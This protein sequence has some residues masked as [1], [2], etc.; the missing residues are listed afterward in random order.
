VPVARDSPRAAPG[1][2]L[3]PT[4]QRELVTYKTEHT[5]FLPSTGGSGGVTY[6]VYTA[7]APNI[8]LALTALI[9]ANKIGTRD[10]GD[11][12]FFFSRGATTTEVL[13]AFT[14]AGYTKALD[15]AKALVDEHDTSLY[16]REQVTKFSGLLTITAGTRT[17]VIDRQTERPL[18]DAER[19]EAKLVFGSSLK[20]DLIRLAEDPAMSVGGYARTTPWT[21]NFPPGRFSQADFMPLLIHELTHS[22]QYQHGVSLFT[23][24]YYAIKA[25]YDYGKEAGLLAAKKAGKGF[26]SFNTEQQGDILEDYYNKLKAGLDVTAWQPFVDEVKATK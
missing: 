10:E 22:W 15:M 18:T 24:I 5:E 13:A 3:A 6:D 16:S 12:S 11:R 26:T 8:R 1:R 2:P 17:Q 25:K 4:I 19:T 21:V 7:D 9:A 14:A 23:T 20:L